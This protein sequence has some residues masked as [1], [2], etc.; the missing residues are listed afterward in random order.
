LED[1]VN[2]KEHLEARRAK[3][4]RQQLMTIL[5]WGGV[6]VVIIGLFGYI[7]WGAVRPAAGQE[8][9]IME[10]YEAHVTEGQD[11]GPFNSDPPTSGPHYRDEYEAGFYDETS[12]EAQ[13][14]Y[15]EGYLGHNLEHGYV[16][17][18]YNC[19]LLDSSACA[20]LKEQIKDSMAENG[21]TKL[22]A[23]PRASIDVPIALTS[24]GQLL[25][26]DEFDARQAKKFV[27][28]NRN[29][30]PEPNAP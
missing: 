5:I 20:E 9:P 13:A 10:N 18:W 26:M 24:W 2:K 25:E 28:A 15:P 16:I 8:I 23:F 4:K 3:K 6:A 27:S 29:R 11:P 7:V 19:D 21:S 12:P 17:Y 30:A 22:I 14:P 1:K